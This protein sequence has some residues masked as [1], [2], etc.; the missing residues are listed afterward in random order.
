MKPGS[1]KPGGRVGEQAEPAE[2]GLALDAGREVVGQRDRLEGAAEH[3]LARVQHEALG[4]VDLDEAGEVGLVQRRVDD[5]V[6]VVVEQPEELVEPHVDAARL[7]HVG[8]PRVEPDPSGLDLGPDVAVGEQH[9]VRVPAGLLGM[10]EAAAG[11]GRAVGLDFRAPGR[12]PQRPATRH[13]D[14]AQW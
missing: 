10:G 12:S 3:E 5:R 7:D 13:A 8:V 11:R 1:T 6:L 14:V 2:A 4:G 9:G